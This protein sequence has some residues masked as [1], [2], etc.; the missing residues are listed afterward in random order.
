MIGEMTNSTDA[1][2]HEETFRRLN[3]VRA[4]ALSHA[5]MAQQ[6]ASERRDIIRSLIDEGFSQAE[7]ARK[8]GVT[9]QA[10]QKMLAL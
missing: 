10:I 7:I 5:R 6:L 4:E 2:R 9:R 1:P 3:R 8:M